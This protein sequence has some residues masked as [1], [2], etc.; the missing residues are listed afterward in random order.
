MSAPVVA[1]PANT[2]TIPRFSAIAGAVFLAILAAVCLMAFI[3]W[4]LGAADNSRAVETQSYAVGYPLHGGL[5]GASR[6]ATVEQTGI[7]IGY[8]MHGGLAGPSRIG[9]NAASSYGVAY[10]LHGGLAG[11]SQVSVFE[12]LTFP[13]G[14]LA[15]PS[16]VEADR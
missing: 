6:I 14:G 11:P 9:A 5:A 15:G 12:G 10:P 3:V 13:H 2:R 4:N 7:G 8:P 1:T 16:R